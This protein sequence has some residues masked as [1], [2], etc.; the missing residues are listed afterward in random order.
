MTT[1]ERET[2]E[3]WAEGAADK[4]NREA[5]AA[6]S[7]AAPQQETAPAGVT[8]EEACEREAARFN[9]SGATPE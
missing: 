8:W 2:W 4:F 1:P 9:G 6:S 3:A 5:E 7:T